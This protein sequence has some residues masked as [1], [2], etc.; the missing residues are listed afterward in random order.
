MQS[1]YKV[2]DT[3]CWK[4]SNPF[5]ILTEHNTEWTSEGDEDYEERIIKLSEEQDKVL[6]DLGI[7]QFEQCLIHFG[8]KN[9]AYTMSV[10]DAIQALALK[11]GAD[12]VEFENGCI[13]FIGY[14]YGFNENWF[15]ILGKEI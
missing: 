3:E 13:G 1:N 7:D 5:R 2:I 9:V 6:S 15:E 8:N 4:V 11:D 12:L 14:Y 10:Y